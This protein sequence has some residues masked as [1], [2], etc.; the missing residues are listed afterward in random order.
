MQKNEFQRMRLCFAID[1]FSTL[2]DHVLLKNTDKDTQQD[3]FRAKILCDEKD[4]SNTLVQFSSCRQY[5]HKVAFKAKRLCNGHDESST[6]VGYVSSHT[7]LHKR[8]CTRETDTHTHTPLQAHTCKNRCPFATH[9]KMRSSGG[10]SAIGK[11]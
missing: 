8:N 1:K 9:G 6:L 10:G 11:E 7:K 4:E 3:N 2:K 5:T